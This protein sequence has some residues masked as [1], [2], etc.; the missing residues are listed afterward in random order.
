MTL[1]EYSLKELLGHY[2]NEVHIIMEPTVM[3][4]GSLNMGLLPWICPDNYEQSMNFIKDCKADWC[5]SHLELQG[6]EI[7]GITQ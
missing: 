2:M 5:G 1:L 3:K 4:Y 7:D 6:F